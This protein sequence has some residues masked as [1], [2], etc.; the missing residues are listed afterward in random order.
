MSDSKITRRRFLGQTAAAIAAAGLGQLP[1]R[2]EAEA[3]DEQKL[4]IKAKPNIVFIMGDDMG[5]ADLSCYG[6]EAI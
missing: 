5:Y 1:F 4:A 3:M 6:R 2:A